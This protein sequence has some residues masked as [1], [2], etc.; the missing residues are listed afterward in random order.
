MKSLFIAIIIICVIVIITVLLPG[1]YNQRKA[2]SQF[3]RAAIAYPAIP[4][5]YC[6]TMF[7]AKDSTIR[8]T[9][10]ISD[11]LYIEGE[12]TTDTIKVND[13]V[14]ITTVKTLPGQTITNTV[15][16]RDTVIRENTAAVKAANIERGKV[17]DLLVLQTAS[18]GKAK[19][20]RNI[21][22][23]IAICS[24][25]VNAIGIYLKFKPKI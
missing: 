20:Q 3:S 18:T 12:T 8:D 17:T 15:H 9:T 23:I 22:M 1:C 11:T 4:A 6:A 13:T 25:A 10:L 7:P 21:W 5:E 2:T 16:I 24:L 19:K 14:R